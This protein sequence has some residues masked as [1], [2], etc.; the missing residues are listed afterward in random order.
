MS[1]TP[2]P[3]P[4]PGA[5]QS[6]N[7]N[8]NSPSTTPPLRPSLQ[9]APR[10]HLYVDQ[11]GMSALDRCIEGENPNPEHVVFFYTFSCADGDTARLMGDHMG[12]CGLAYTC[13][14]RERDIERPIYVTGACIPPDQLNKEELEHLMLIK[15]PANNHTFDADLSDQDKDTARTSLREFLIRE[16]KGPH[17]FMVESLSGQALSATT[18]ETRII[19]NAFDTNKS[20][21]IFI[22]VNL[23]F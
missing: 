17:R 3:V 11:N 12:K 19:M 1:N 5:C 8:T 20:K 15:P 22:S 9:R 14:G 13:F 23:P 2:T 16:S 7:P 18:P 4:T 21:H 10:M 6:P